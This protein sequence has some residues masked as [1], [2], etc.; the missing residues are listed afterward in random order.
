MDVN[1]KKQIDSILANIKSELYD[2]FG[3]DEALAF[4]KWSKKALFDTIADRKEKALLYQLKTC[5]DTDIAKLRKKKREYLPKNYPQ[6]LTIGDIVHVSYGFGY[7]SELSDGHYAIIFSNIKA[8]MYFV[9]PISSEPLK[10]HMFYFDD[11]CVSTND[12]NKTKRKSYLRFDQM[13]NVHYR[14]LENAR[15]GERENIGPEKLREASVQVGI[16]LGISN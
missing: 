12:D 2:N 6:N 5:N 10:S 3:D 13:G 14:R 4:V 7:C 16:F 11:L 9:I 8:N 1:T 15:I